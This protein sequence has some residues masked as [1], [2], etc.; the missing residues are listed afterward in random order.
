MTDQAQPLTPT[1]PAD[2]AL[3]VLARHAKEQALSAEPA[4]GQP[5]MRPVWR[6]V[7][8]FCGQLNR[9]IRQLPEGVRSLFVAE[10]IATMLSMGLSSTPADSPERQAWRMGYAVLLG[11][12][13]QQGVPPKQRVGDV[14]VAASLWA[15]LQ[16]MALE[17]AMSDLR[18]KV[19]AP[20]QNAQAEAQALRQQ[21]FELREML[22]T[23]WAEAMMAMGGV[24]LAQQHQQAP[25][26]VPAQETPADGG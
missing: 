2:T 16:R 4:E 11:T 18:P 5:D 21:L 1:T 3:R 19:L 13:Q 25:G 20:G 12:L 26:V 7:G 10:H 23:D 22:I 8:I 6:F 14:V 17:M 9:L 15:C 24:L